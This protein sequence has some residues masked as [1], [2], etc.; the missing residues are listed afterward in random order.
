MAH[1]IKKNS[2][3]VDAGFISKTAAVASYCETRINGNPSGHKMQI[4]E[5]VYFAEAGYAIYAT[6]IITNTKPVRKMYSLEDLFNFYQETGIKSKKYWFSIANEKIFL[7]GKKFKY[8]S[9]FEYEVDRQGLDRHIILPKEFRGQSSYHF[10]KDNHKF[11]ESEKNFELS[12]KIPSALRLHLFNKWNVG[13][14]KPMI[15]IDHF[16]PESL[17]GPGNIEENLEIV[18]LSINRRKGNSVPRGLF[19]LGKDF[20]KMK[21]INLTVPEKLIINK[22]SLENSPEG[23]DVAMK[24]IKLINSKE[25]CLSE[26]RDFYASVKKFHR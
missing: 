6:G 8:L 15:D 12:P 16:I 4:G 7:Q 13:Y 9:V 2:N 17:G 20:C 1:L 11:D 26:I 19:I 3:M 10:I 25:N 23:K 22:A 21:G 14:D 5:K 24:I 18:G